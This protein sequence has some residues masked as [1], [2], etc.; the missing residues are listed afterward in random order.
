ML[1][2]NLRLKQGNIQTLTALVRYHPFY[3]LNDLNIFYSIPAPLFTMSTINVIN[4]GRNTNNPNA[5]PTLST[6]SNFEN[7]DFNVF[8]IYGFKC[9][10]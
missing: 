2:F 9:D 3:I 1:N 8:I 5:A 7:F 10:Y 6:V 4:N